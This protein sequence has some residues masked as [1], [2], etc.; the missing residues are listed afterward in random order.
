LG[1]ALTGFLVFLPLKRNRNRIAGSIC[2]GVLLLIASI[3]ACGCGSSGPSTPQ[4]AKVSPG[5][6]TIN[7]VA[8]DSSANR[9]TQSIT[10][11]V[12]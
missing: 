3:S 4:L 5:T 6:Y 11:I 10:L 12:Q 1:V 2:F 7:V 8:G 9:V